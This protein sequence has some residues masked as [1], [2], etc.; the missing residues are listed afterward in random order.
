MILGII[1]AFTGNERIR[2]HLLEISNKSFFGE[3]IGFQM[4]TFFALLTSGY[5][6]V[7]NT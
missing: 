4:E 6:G 7:S 1:G 3:I 5:I 2:N